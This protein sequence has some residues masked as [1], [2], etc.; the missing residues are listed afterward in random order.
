M[1]NIIR[2]LPLLPLCKDLHKCKIFMHWDNGRTLPLNSDVD[3]FR[4]LTA[5]ELAEEQENEIDEDNGPVM[6]M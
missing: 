6:G 1:L 3:S 4:K 2:N 5:E